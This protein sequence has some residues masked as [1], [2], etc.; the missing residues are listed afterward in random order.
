MTYI[1][2]VNCTITGSNGTAI[3]LY[4]SNLNLYDNIHFENNHAKYGG[5]V[6]VCERSF[7]FLHNNSYVQFINNTALM[8]G[9]VFIHQSCL[10]TVSLCAFQPAMLEDMPIEEFNRFLKLEF[11]NNSASIA[12]DVIYGGSLAT[13]Y[14]IGRYSYHHRSKSFF[15][16]LNIYKEVFNVITQRG[17]SPIS[18]YAEGVCFCDITRSEMTPKCQ[19]DHQLVEAYPGEEFRVSAFTVGQLNGSTIGTIQSS[20]VGQSH[21]HQLVV[22]NGG[23]YSNQCIPLSFSVLSNESTATIVLRPSVEYY[24]EHFMVNF[25]V[26]LLLCPLGFELIE[27]GGQY[28]CD[29]STLFHYHLGI[30]SCTIECDITT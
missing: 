21:F 27:Q 30:F 3:S 7:I 9:A 5:A 29:C 20:L 8:G 2:M 1:K 13:C 28:K 12:G 11:V 14:T 26:H 15:N 16:F 24:N 18:S 19:R 25:T 10:E 23:I 6:K 22:H 4:N 17:P